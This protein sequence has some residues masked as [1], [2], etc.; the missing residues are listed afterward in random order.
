M[1]LGELSL[2]SKHGIAMRVEV[3]EP[4]SVS[5]DHD[6]LKQDR[7]LFGFDT[8][9][10]QNEVELNEPIPNV[11]VHPL[12]IPVQGDYIT[13]SYKDARY[14]SGPYRVKLWLMI[15]E[16]PTPLSE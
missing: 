16:E 14:A 11:P 2:F 8:N 3:S 12:D 9:G 7:Y 6:R 13:G 4:T 1:I 5:R 15:E 10:N